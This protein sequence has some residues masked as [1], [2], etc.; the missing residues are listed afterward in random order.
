M[1]RTMLFCL[2]L[3]MLASPL[4]SAAAEKIDGDKLFDQ[5][6]L[7]EVK[8]ELPADE[9]D[10]QRGLMRSF[11]GDHTAKPFT[12]I[13]GDVW[14]DGI[15]I[16]SV[17]IRKKGFFGSMDAER[18]SVKIKFDEFVDQDPVTG[19]S[20]ITLNNNKQDSSQS[21]QIL[22]Y[23]LFNAA[24]LYAPRC[25]LARVTLNGKFL[26]IYTH[27]E[28]VKKPFLKRRFGDSS[29][30][31]YEGTIAD[32]YPK[33]IG[34][35]EAKGDAAEK[36]RSKILRLAEIVSSA[37][38]LDMAELEK[39]VNIDYFLKFWAIEGMVAFW[40]GYGNNQNNYF[41]YDRPQDEK[42]YFIPW[43]AD[44]SFV[45]FLGPFGRFGGNSSTTSLVYSQ[46]MLTNRL[47]HSPG[48]PDRFRDIVLGFLNTVWQEDELL[49]EM[50]RIA[51]L[52]DGHL[53]E[54]QASE[55]TS[56]QMRQFISSRR[57]AILEEF[58]E[59]PVEVRDQPRKPTYQ[60][61]VGV[62]QGSFATVWHEE[63]VQNGTEV[64]KAELQLLLDGE[65]VKF[66]QLGVVA[67]TFQ[68]QQSRFGA[69]RRGSSA[70]QGEEGRSAR[71]AAADSAEEKPSET[72]QDR[73]RPANQAPSRNQERRAAPSNP[74]A[75]MA[76][77]AMIVFAGTRA[78]DGERVT[79]TF[80]MD[81]AEFAASSNKTIQVRGS[82][83]EG[84]AGGR[85]GGF[86]GGRRRS[87]VG[88]MKLGETGIVAG[89]PVEGDFIGKVTE[90]R[91][92]IFGGGGR[93]GASRGGN[94]TNRPAVR[95]PSFFKAAQ[96][97]QLDRNK[98]KKITKEEIP[99]RMQT[100]ILGRVDT[101]KDGLID[102]AELEDLRKTES[103]KEADKK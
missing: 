50:D 43:G 23:K 54:R 83:T 77:Q 48:M 8:I 65:P 57:E 5:H 31:L 58:E 68:F 11:S 32:F 90:S 27:V 73:N 24:G 99:E 28:S 103:S 97:Q 62:A 7:I 34:N 88:E 6:R 91:G 56:N 69:S 75:Q 78:A 44:S 30:K 84:Q 98:D 15:K 10:K 63:A 40:D 89:D 86:G 3:L 87:V 14:I 60:V 61:E 22:T 76:P 21:S 70:R 52:V 100:L 71:P 29:G 33:G 16:E 55:R 92:G 82:I 36:D 101:N 39:L 20:R 93:G 96:L 13:R 2:T 51:E 64:G 19:L 46:S 37:E 102:E 67:Q 4:P 26:G 49:A 81:R 42:L 80:M 74:F 94:Q 66:T 41:V 72:R 35:I 95:R 1:L 45:S 17:G 18:P 47:Y 79:L 38:P 59:W 53:H 9:W 25:S 12:Y 85:F